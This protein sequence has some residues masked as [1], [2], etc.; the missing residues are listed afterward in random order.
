M[1]TEAESK[2][3]CDWCKQP[4]GERGVK[5][6]ESADGWNL[7]WNQYFCSNDHASRYFACID[8]GKGCEDMPN[9]RGEVR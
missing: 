5:T 2:F 3:L 7:R 8:E 4:I 6:Y 1:R 9:D